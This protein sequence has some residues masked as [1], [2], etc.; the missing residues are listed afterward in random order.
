MDR[1]YLTANQV[2]ERFGK[3]SDMT[4]WRW[5]Q[6]DELGFPKPVV[7]QRRRFFRLDDIEHFEANRLVQAA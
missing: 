1:R 3:I 5:L 4:L 6:D 2:R 7:I